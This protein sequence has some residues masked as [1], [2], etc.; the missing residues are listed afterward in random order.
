MAEITAEDIK[1]LVA[2][3]LVLATTFIKAE[4][5]GQVQSGYVHSPRANYLDEVLRLYKQALE[6]LE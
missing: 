2:S 4:L 6:S 5:S 3:N 1:K